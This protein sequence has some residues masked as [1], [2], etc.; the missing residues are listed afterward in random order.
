[1]KSWALIKAIIVHSSPLGCINENQTET[2]E[3][4]PGL[5][6]V[7]LWFKHK[8]Y[9]FGGR[10]FPPDSS[11]AIS[12]TNFVIGETFKRIGLL[13]FE[14][15]SHFAVKSN[16]TSVTRLSWYSLLR[17]NKWVFHPNK[18]FKHSLHWW[19]EKLATHQDDTG[20]ENSTCNQRIPNKQILNM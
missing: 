2:T 20:Q 8:K 14:K 1:M 15:N 9:N 11:I 5:R 13:V 4:A 7:S 18:T 6:R 12:V 17:G 16:E 3:L 19:Y 10:V